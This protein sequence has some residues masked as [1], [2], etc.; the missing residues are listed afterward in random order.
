MYKYLY[1][2]RKNLLIEFYQ[3]TLTP[4]GNATK[5]NTYNFFGANEN[6]SYRKIKESATIG[7]KLD[8]STQTLPCN[9]TD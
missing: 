8:C 1:L 6:I 5:G 9:C 7:K 4:R 2:R 3:K